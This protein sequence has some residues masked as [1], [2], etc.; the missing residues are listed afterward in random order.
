MN[1]T[2]VTM[3]TRTKQRRKILKWVACPLAVVLFLVAVA[4]LGGYWYVTRSLPATKGEKSVSELHQ[5]VAVIRDSRGVAKIVAADLEDLFTIQGYTVAQDRLFQMDLTRR[6]AS[7]T[8][9]EVVGETALEMDRFFRVYGMHRMTEGMAAK[10][11]VETRKA[12]DAYVRGVNMYIEESFGANKQPM[13]FKVLGYQPKPW[14]IDDTFLVIKYMGYMLAG[15]YNEEL[16]HY[17]LLKTLGEDGKALLPYYDEALFPTIYHH[18]ESPFSK[19]ALDRLAAFA[20]PPH[21]GSNNWVISG[22]LSESGFPLIGNDPHLE[23]AIP[24]I[25]Y[26]THLQLKGDFQ[27]VG[28]T[29]PGV[30][31]VVLGH[32]EQMAWGVTS[33]MA[34]TQ[35]LFLERVHPEKPSFYRFGDKWEEAE[36]IKEVI[37][38]KDGEPHVEWVEVTRNGPIVNKVVKKEGPYQAISLAWSGREPGSELNAM[39]QFLRAKDVH[40]FSDSLDGFVTPALNWVFADRDGNIAYRGQGL[41]PIRKKGDGSLPVPGWDPRYQWA[42]FIPDRELPQVINPEKGY[43]I[44]ANNK[45]VDDDYPYVINRNFHPYRAERLTEIVEEAIAADKKITVDTMREMQVDFTNTQARAL[46]PHVLSALKANKKQL[47]SSEQEAVVLLEGWDFVES[48]SSPEALIWHLWYDRF[49]DAVEERLGKRLISSLVVHRLMTEAERPAFIK[50]W[51]GGY[52]A[53]AGAKGQSSVSASDTSVAASARKEQSFQTVALQAFQAAVAQAV[54]LQGKDP[55]KWAWGRWHR[56][57]LK[58][59][60]GVVKPLNLLFN[61]GSWSLGGSSATPGANGYDLETGVVNHGGGWRMA[62][63]LARMDTFYDMLL[64]GQSG[65]VFSPYYDDQL[66]DW[67]A[68]KLQPMVWETEKEPQAETILYKPAKQ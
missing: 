41:I 20:P 54:D 24:G 7:G 39:L 61:R 18:N 49:M 13:E 14:T 65:Q 22:K 40:E 12:V 42:G 23:L 52:S 35:D 38:V 59:P 31:G 28:V 67:V 47:S 30:P 56:L 8:I 19:Q 43:V 50:L 32:N 55:Q 17:H 68:G 58:H 21:N 2:P 11:D 10:L 66:N 25:W 16:L 6:A 29:V 53:G 37:A 26:Q 15:N 3:P 36:R 33:L 45:P 1:G 63:D 62:G 60:L 64:P 9:S 34:D 57:E 5:P 4:S 27:A 48:A 51:N 46:L 44:T